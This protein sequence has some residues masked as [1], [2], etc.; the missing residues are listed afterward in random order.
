VEA[1]SQGYCI[2]ATLQ[3]DQADEAL[4]Q[5]LGEWGDSLVL[6]SSESYLNVHL[7][8]SD[9]RTVRRHLGD[10]GHVVSWSEE[11]IDGQ[12]DWRNGVF[13]TNLHLMTDAAGSL[14]RENSRHYGFTLLDSYILDEQAAYPETL[15]SPANLYR[16]M[17]SGRVINTSQ[18]SVYERQQHYQSILSRYEN[19]VY[20][21]VGSAFTGNYNVAKAWLEENGF[22]D[23]MRLIDT[24]AASGRL[25][26]SVLAAACYI[27]YAHDLDD[28]VRF[29]RSAIFHCREYIFLDRLHYLAKGGRL[30]KKSAFFGDL[31]HMKPIVSPEEQGAVKV[32]VARNERHQL[33]FARNKLQECFDKE[34]A[35]L[36]MLEYTDNQ[37]WVET[38]ACEYVREVVPAAKIV[39]QPMSLTSAAHMGPGTWG[40]SFLPEEIGLYFDEGCGTDTSQE[41]SSITRTQ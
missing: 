9:T 13:S 19:V 20:L 8:A 41:E 33:Q 34:N 14:T 17:K 29:A 12:F 24:G 1:G 16:F 40:I 28:L 32:G 5:G 26:L 10:L 23:R 25:G 2:N 4:A 3:S 39:F 37:E 21:C 22:Q 11:K 7:H 36:I 35:P 15:C 18:A 38:V 6:S 30:S 27:R 31:M